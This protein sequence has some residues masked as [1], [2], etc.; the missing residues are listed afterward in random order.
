M[1]LIVPPVSFN[2]LCIGACSPPS[3]RC[4]QYALDT[5]EH[6]SQKVKESCFGKHK[7][8]CGA[9]EHEGTERDTPSRGFLIYVIV[10]KVI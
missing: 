8:G 1:S 5:H 3:L 4:G 6:N 2:H 10:T 7:Q 9:K